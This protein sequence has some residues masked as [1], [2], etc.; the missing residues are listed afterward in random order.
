MR[1]RQRRARQC[2]LSFHKHGFVRYPT[3]SF[4]SPPRGAL[5]SQRW[6]RLRVLHQ[7][8]AVPEWFFSQA[9]TTF[10]LV[11]DPLK[12]FCWEILKF[13][14][15]F[16]KDLLQ[17]HFGSGAARIRNDFCLLK[18][19]DTSGSGSTTQHYFA[20]RTSRS[21]G[22]VGSGTVNVGIR[23]TFGE[24]P[25]LSLV[26]KFILLGCIPYLSVTFWYGADPDSWSMPLD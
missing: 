15:F 9:D 12:H 20:Q 19:S 26:L 2:H 8:V 14:Q 17:I 18:V 5:V 10:Q 21:H 25:F 1:R 16:R 22:K 13:Y 24:A 6:T 7:C 3:G 23:D 11:P 4:L